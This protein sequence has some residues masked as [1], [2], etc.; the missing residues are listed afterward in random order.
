MSLFERLDELAA[1]GEPAALLTIVRKDGSAPRDVGDKMVVTADEEYGT[2]GGGTVEHLAVQDARSVLSEADKPGVRTYE[3][4]RGGNTGMVCGGEMDVFID[5]VRGQAQLYIA[6]GGHIGV[7][8]APLAERLGYAVTVV[9][10]REAYA[11]P[12]QFPNDTD[13]IHG[14]YGEALGGLP[15]G[16]ETAVVVATRSGTFDREAVAAA[17]DGEAGYVGLVASETK[18]DHVLGSL[19]EAG[20]SRRELSRVRTPVGLDLG[21]SGPAA[22]ALSVLSEV[23]MDRHDATGERATRLNLDDLVVV[24]GGGDLGSGVVYRLQQAGFPVIVAEVEQPTVVRRAVAFG[25]ALYEDEVTVEGV[26]GRAAA[27][28]DEALGLLAD[29]VVPVIVDPDAAV[30]SELDATVLVDAIMAK[31][32]FDTGTRR[33][34]ADIV[35]GMGP[36][37]E[38]GEDVDA[39]IE[40][41]RGHEL[42]R[43]FYEGTASQYDG[44]PGKRRGYTHERVLRAPA[45]GDWTPTV[46]IGDSV[47]AGDVVGTVGDRPV[48]TEIGGLVRGLVHGGLRVED[49]AKLGDVDPRGESVDPT[50]ISD[51]ALCLGGGVLEAVLR[52]R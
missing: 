44:E 51:K 3:L 35:V 17:L 2:I 4:E 5:R 41:D 32:K 49:G 20:Y 47:T 19:A 27:D 12:G 42:G 13:V 30:A 38:A 26:P 18:A 40:T 21:G 25:A 43:V 9:D 31:G 7:E 52:L 14:D 46:G 15:M 28:I 48:E 36:G 23:S 50:K 11:D 1:R 34:D 24:R 6:G 39:V 33:S 16:R 37:F 22:V 8:L 29:D 10:D 45:D